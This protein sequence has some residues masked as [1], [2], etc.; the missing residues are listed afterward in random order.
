MSAAAK[1]KDK[2]AEIERALKDAHIPS[3]AMALVQALE[4][5]E[6]IWRRHWV[7]EALPAPS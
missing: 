5:V 1:A 2:S 4:L 7:R 3:L 6:T